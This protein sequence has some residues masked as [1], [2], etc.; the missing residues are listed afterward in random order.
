MQARTLISD[1]IP[2]AK[3]TDK[4]SRVI[5]W[6]SEFKVNFLPVL[7][8]KSL[9]GIVQESDLLDLENEDQDLSE[10]HLALNET[11]CVYEDSHIYEAARMMAQFKLDL[12]PVLDTHSHYMGLITREKLIE[13]LALGL[14]VHE[15]G[16][17]IV[18]EVNHN[19]YHLSEIG[20]ICES[21]DAKVLSL[22]IHNAPSPHRMRITI[23]LNI[24]ELTRVIATFER[25]NYDIHTV[26]FDAEQM[27]D[28]R[29]N[30][31]A[32]VKY[33]NI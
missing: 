25:F 31:E 33:L 8:G 32:L 16:G 27:D 28:F 9:I 7:K 29:E 11:T 17:I 12:L 15:P 22:T 20:R 4:A 14:N 3:L 5:N 24:R 19:S 10:I 26:I 21:N 23:K 2:P 13:H 1:S 18:L 6:M 30:F